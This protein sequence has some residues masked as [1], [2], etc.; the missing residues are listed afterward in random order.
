MMTCPLVTSMV[1]NNASPML[2]RISMFPMPAATGSSNVSA[3]IASMATSTAPSKGLRAVTDGDL[4]SLTSI[5]IESV[6]VLPPVSVALEVTVWM[7][8]DRA[9]VSRLNVHESS[10]TAG[11][12]APPSIWTST[13]DSAVLSNAVPEMTM[14]PVT[15]A[16][17]K[18]NVMATVGGVMSVE[19][20][21]SAD[22]ARLPRA[23]L[24]STR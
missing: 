3:R 14:V 9:V 5:E 20:V 7:P 22:T 21:K 12:K 13:T 10:P 19:T 4:V 23:S 6:V 18:G 11:S 16:P 8:S 15:V 17:S 2:S 24:E 1:S